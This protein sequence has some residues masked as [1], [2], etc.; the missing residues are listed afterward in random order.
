ML[1]VRLPYG[2]TGRRAILEY[3]VIADAISLCVCPY[4]LEASLHAVIRKAL[5]CS[6]MRSNRLRGF[7]VTRESGPNIIS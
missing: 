1:I 4:H 2:N 7:T 6:R 5:T 3:G